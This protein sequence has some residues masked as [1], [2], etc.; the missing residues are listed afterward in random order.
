M[1]WSHRE[2]SEQSHAYHCSVSSSVLPD[3]DSRHGQG[4]DC[5]HGTGDRCLKPSSPTDVGLHCEKACRAAL[6]MNLKGSSGRD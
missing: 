3:R 6:R 1:R 4:S 5:L 2:Q